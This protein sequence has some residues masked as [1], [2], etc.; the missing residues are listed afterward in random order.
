M[1]PQKAF[2]GVSATG[3]ENVIP[4]HV[5][6]QPDIRPPM[7]RK[8][9]ACSS[10]L[11]VRSSSSASSLPSAGTMPTS[12]SSSWSALRRPPPLPLA[13][14]Q[15]A[16]QAAQQQLGRSLSSGQVRV[17]TEHARAISRRSLLDHARRM[18]GARQY[19]GRELPGWGG[20]WYGPPTEADMHT[21]EGS[22]MR[23][24]AETTAF[25]RSSE[26][27]TM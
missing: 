27:F 3:W 22:S 19:R 4:R 1:M 9:P 24:Q 12:A 2:V 5:V 20:R 14:A 25:A 8:A 26:R 23:R 17:S 18:N 21:V 11:R 10:S 6:P 16:A 13:A 15:A 7:H